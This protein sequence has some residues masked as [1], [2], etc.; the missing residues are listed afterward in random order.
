MKMLKLVSFSAALALGSALTTEAQ[1]WEP[2]MHKAE[3]EAAIDLM[4]SSYAMPAM[5]GAYQ[6]IS[7]CK[8]TPTSAS[9]TF[10]EA[11]GDGAQQLDKMLDTA[12]CGW[13]IWGCENTSTKRSLGIRT[14]NYTSVWH[15]LVANQGS[16]P[17][18]NP[19]GGYYYPRRPQTSVIRG[20]LDI[21]F[22]VAAFL[23]N[24]NLRDGDYDTTEAHYRQGSYSTRKQYEDYQT[25]AWQPADNVAAYWYSQW[26]ATKSCSSL[27]MVLHV[28]G[29]MFVPMHVTGT[30][31]FN[32]GDYEPWAWD[33][34]WSLGMNSLET[35]SQYTNLAVPSTDIRV[36]L[37]DAARGTLGRTQPMYDSSDAVRTSA[38][39]QGAA[40]AIGLMTTVMVKAASE[41]TA[42][43]TFSPAAMRL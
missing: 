35:A 43:P 19:F 31:G 2:G 32:H 16:D 23:W 5:R 39:R 33:R 24:L 11:I 10:R 12:L 8:F 1:A 29:D 9:P 3:A 14:N 42:T 30:L 41:F 6:T 37:R 25:T 38:A 18:K 15:F 34:F 27:G 40:R 20:E 21:D 7:T 36:I 22:V 17:H 4:K 13:W 28:T 26:K